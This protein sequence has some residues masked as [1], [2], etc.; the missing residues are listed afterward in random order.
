MR[1]LKAMQADMK[2]AIKPHR[3]VVVELATMGKRMMYLTYV[4]GG[5]IAASKQVGPM[6]QDEHDWE[7]ERSYAE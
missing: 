2:W 6:L 4:G 7:L 5:K 3:P 1:L